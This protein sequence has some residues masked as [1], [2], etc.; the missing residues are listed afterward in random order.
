MSVSVC[1]VDCGA[2]QLSLQADCNVFCN[3][4]TF[5]AFSQSG[6][7]ASWQRK[8]TKGCEG[9][10]KDA[11]DF[12]FHRDTLRAVS[13]VDAWPMARWGP[14]PKTR[15]RLQSSRMQPTCDTMAADYLDRILKRDRNDRTFLKD[16]NLNSIR[17][18]ASQSTLTLS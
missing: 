15:V 6:K 4:G 14:E 11:H 2:G 13:G 10:V 5:V 12:R 16:S 1:G 3:R 7:P 9:L 17:N 18:A 8:P